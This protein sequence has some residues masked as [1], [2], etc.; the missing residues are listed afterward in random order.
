MKNRLGRAESVPAADYD[1]R[2]GEELSQA[3]SES[4]IPEAGLRR[5][6][7][8]ADVLAPLLQELLCLSDEVSLPPADPHSDHLSSRA[9]YEVD[10]GRP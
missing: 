8:A 6:R 10:R 5:A 4:G 7:R 2:D 1:H 9:G 3:L